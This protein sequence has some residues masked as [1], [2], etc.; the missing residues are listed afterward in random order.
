M[1]KSSNRILILDNNPLL[2]GHIKDLL[3]AKGLQCEITAN[4]R[5][6]LNK[7]QS[8][9]FVLVLIDHDKPEID[10]LEFLN[11][12]GKKDHL[13]PP[14]VIVLS[15]K[16]NKTIR[17]KALRAGAYAIVEKPYRKDEL[18]LV[19][20]RAIKRYAQILSRRPCPGH[21]PLMY[22]VSCS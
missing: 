5:R 14:L 16:T 15:S 8:H 18:R 17:K 11:A 3:D 2:K 21:N 10:G 9:E 12:L 4:S 6:G 7:L 22:E 19:I 13:E 1:G 20:T